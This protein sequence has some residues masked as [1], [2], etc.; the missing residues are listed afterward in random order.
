VKK[1]K[2]GKNMDNINLKAYLANIG[3]TITE[4][5]NK[6]DCNRAYMS[7]IVS[8]KKLPGRRLAKDI[9][10]ATK[11]IVNLKTKAKDCQKHQKQE[12][13]QDSQS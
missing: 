7:G 13:N 4:F 1:S 11:G 9:F 2:R 5:C 8:G 10:E 3:M 12:Q 6:L